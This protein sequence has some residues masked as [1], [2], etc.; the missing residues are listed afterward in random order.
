MTRL[1]LR[2]FALITAGVAAVCTAA[3]TTAQGDGPGRAAL[4][5]A[6]PAW[7][8]AASSATAVPA[9]A[10]TISAKVWL[11]PR[12]AAQLDALA[13]AVSEP[14]SPQYGQFLS[15]DQ[16]RAQYAPTAAQVA[17]VSSWLTGAGLSVS[18]VGTDNRFVEV[19]GTGRGDRGGLRHPARPLRRC[20]PDRACARERPLRPGQA[21]RRRPG[22]DRP[23]HARAARRRR[24]ISAPKR[25]W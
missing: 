14:S 5:Q 21:G 17:Q 3:A 24:K 23:V 19:S 9:G 12:N 10:G 18:A 15:A 7:T 22:R 25:R 13:K 20:G 11:A 16:F 4:T 8:T 1:G 2:R 6:K